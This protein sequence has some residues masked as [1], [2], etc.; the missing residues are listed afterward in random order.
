MPH[1]ALVPVRQD[2]LRWISMLAGASGV[3]LG[4]ANAPPA[5][6][7][8]TSTSDAKQQVG[9]LRYASQVIPPARAPDLGRQS[10]A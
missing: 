1:S 9:G 2:L 10:R 6:R 3:G 4:S 7:S 5:P 8:V